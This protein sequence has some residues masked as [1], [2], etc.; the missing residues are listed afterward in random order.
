MKYVILGGGGIFANHFADFLL[1]KGHQVIAVG[2][3]PRGKDCFT[4][5]VGKNNPD[6]AYHQIHIVFEQKRLFALLDKVKPDYVV[7]FAALAYANS[8]DEPEL[9]YQTNC[10]AVVNIVGFLKGKDYLKKFIQ[11]GSSEV[12]GSSELPAKETDKVNPTSPYAVSK[13]A[14]DM[15][16]LTM[17]V[18]MNI[19]RPSNCYGPGQYTYR[20]IPKAILYFLND[21]V[22]PLE[23]GGIAEKSFMYVDDLSEAIYLVCEKGAVNEI[24]NVGSDSPVTM[25]EMVTRICQILRKSTCEFIIDTPGRSGED[26]RYWIDS[27]KIKELGWK[28]KVSMDDGLLRMVEWCKT[29]PCLSE[30]PA[31]FVLRA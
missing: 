6:Y 26:K 15:H 17:N 31:Y 7:N 21:M 19:L 12:Y 20:I 10:M 5:K 28:Q 22:F 14:A 13:L 23:G 27:A 30:E 1:K 11:I 2:R 9:F 18:P 4:L 16:L 3:N 24:Y 25:K 29:Y 8:W